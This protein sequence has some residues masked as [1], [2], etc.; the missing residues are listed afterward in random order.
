[1]FGSLRTAATAPVRLAREQLAQ[2]E[3]GA[4]TTGQLQVQELVER[5]QQL[6]RALASDIT[7]QQRLQLETALSALGL[8]NQAVQ[9]LIESQFPTGTVSTRTKQD[10]FGVIFDPIPIFAPQRALFE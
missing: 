4:V 10:T 8:S 5:Q 7:G 6:A 3:A 9:N 2:R 1:M